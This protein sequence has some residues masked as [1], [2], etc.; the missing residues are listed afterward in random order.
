MLRD[1]DILLKSAALEAVLFSE[2]DE[3]PGDPCPGGVTDCPFCE[4]TDG[5]D[6]GIV[7]ARALWYAC[8]TASTETPN[9]SATFARRLFMK[10]GFLAVLPC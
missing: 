9:L 1:T 8:V 4:G 7:V 10:L 6:G 5:G 3:C 2:L